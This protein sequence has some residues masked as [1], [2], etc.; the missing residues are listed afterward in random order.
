MRGPVTSFYQFEGNLR[1]ISEK[2][3][4]GRSGF[5]NRRKSDAEIEGT[6]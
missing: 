3:I 1:N 6:A 2:G 5:V 4:S